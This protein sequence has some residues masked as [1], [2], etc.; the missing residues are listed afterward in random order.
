MWYTEPDSIGCP[1]FGHFER[2]PKCPSF[3]QFIDVRCVLALCSSN[4]VSH[5]PNLSPQVSFDLFTVY[6]SLPT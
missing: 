2:C 1:E 5:F 3:R 4:H 6:A